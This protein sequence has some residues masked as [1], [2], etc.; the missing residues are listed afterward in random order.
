MLDAVVHGLES[1][2]TE[3]LVPS[4][5][6]GELFASGSAFSRASSEELPLAEGSYLTQ[7]YTPF[8]LAGI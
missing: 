8:W 1:F 3:A 2:R 5:A 6:G 7:G 4:A